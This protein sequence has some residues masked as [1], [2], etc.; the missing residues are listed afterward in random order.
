MR[1]RVVLL[2]SITRGLQNR[3]RSLL[4]ALQKHNRSVWSLRE[5][6]CMRLI[7]SWNPADTGVSSEQDTYVWFAGFA[8]LDNSPDPKRVH[9]NWDFH[10]L[11]FSLYGIAGFHQRRGQVGILSRF[12]TPPPPPPTTMDFLKCR[13]QKSI[14]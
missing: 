4:V 13:N 12:S 6:Q 14:G 2:C 7:C 1:R 10:Y 3:R 9:I 5:S 8:H 11:G